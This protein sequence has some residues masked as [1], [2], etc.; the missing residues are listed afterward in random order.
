MGTSLN[1]TDKEYKL[2]LFQNNDTRKLSKTM[3]RR[4]LKR[5]KKI[6]KLFFIQDKKLAIYRE[7]E[8]GR[9]T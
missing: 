4:E 3:T 2:K 8:N 5:R 7:D 6:E 1:M 9:N